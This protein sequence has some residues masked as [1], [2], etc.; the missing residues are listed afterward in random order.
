MV[1][2]NVPG[3]RRF[4]DQAPRQRAENHGFSGR[5]DTRL[6]SLDRHDE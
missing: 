3:L 6:L 5:C 1:R 4:L 2:V